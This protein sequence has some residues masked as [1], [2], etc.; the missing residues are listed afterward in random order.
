M[1]SHETRY[2]HARKTQ[3]DYA[4]QT[5]DDTPNGKGNIDQTLLKYS[6]ETHP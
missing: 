1:D 2:K 3:K 4:A 5:R 6:S